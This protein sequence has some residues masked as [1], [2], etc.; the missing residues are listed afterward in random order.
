MDCDHWLIEKSTLICRDG[1]RVWWLHNS[2]CKISCV[3]EK[4]V[5]ISDRPCSSEPILHKNEARPIWW[6]PTKLPYGTIGSNEV[7]SKEHLQLALEAARDGIVLLKNTDS[8][9]PLPKTSLSVSVIGPNANASSLVSLG[10]YYGRPCKLV[11]LLQGFEG[12]SKDTTYHPGCDD[13]P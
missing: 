4:I 7:C 10:S 3:A 11:T 12:Y 2:A 6:E 5:N 9:L 8:L 1:C 13:G